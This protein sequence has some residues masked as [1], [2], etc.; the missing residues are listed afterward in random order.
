MRALAGEFTIQGLSVQPVF[1]VNR[2][3]RLRREEFGYGANWTTP[4]NPQ[5]LWLSAL[6]LM[7][8]D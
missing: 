1:L 3:H 8:A 5:R 7:F 2:T 6:S 4:S